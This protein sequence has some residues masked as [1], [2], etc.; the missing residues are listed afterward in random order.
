[1]DKSL[2]IKNNH[3][4]LML[5]E[6]IHVPGDMDIF[7]ID[8]NY[9]YIVYNKNYEDYLKRTFNIEI[10]EGDNILEIF[11][12][13]Q[14]VNKEKIIFD[15]ALGG[16]EFSQVGNYEENNQI[17]YY[18]DIYK[19]LKDENGEVAG[20]VV[21]YTNITGRKRYER[22]WEIL[23]NISEKVNTN[24]SLR[25]FIEY[26]RNQLS[27][28]INTS[29]FYVSLYNEKNDTYTFPYFV[30]EFDKVD[31]VKQYSLDKS[32]TDYVRKS[33]SPLLK[34]RAKSEE[35]RKSGKIEV[36]GTNSV[37]WLGVPLKIED[38]TIGVMVVQ[39]YVKEKLYTS[40]DVDL[41][42]FI[43]GHIAHAVKRKQAENELRITTNSL[44]YAQSIAKLGQCKFNIQNR[45]V[46]LS[47]EARVIFGFEYDENTVLISDIEEL[48]Y[49]K[50]KNSIQEILDNT[51][52]INEIFE[53]DIR[54]INK[55]TKQLVFVHTK[56]ELES[57]RKDKGDIINVMIQDVTKQ[58]RDK[59]ELKKAKEKAE[60]SDKLKS[61]FLAN[62]SH[63]IR[64]PMNAIVGFS[65]LMAKPKLALKSR[66]RYADF[67]NSSANN[68]MKLINDII[69][70]AKIEA[71]QISII[72]KP[73]NV[74]KML[75]ELYTS[76]LQLRKN[77]K[78]EYIG[79]SVKK[80]VK[81]EIFYIV[82]D[83]LR[84]SQ[85]LSNL[86]NNAIKFI[87]EGF[88]EFGYNFVDSKTL[89]F[90][91][92][93]TGPGIPKDKEELI[94]SRFGQIIDNE[95]VHPGGTGLGLSITK[96]LVEA[97]DG[98]IRFDSEPE[99]GSTFY[100]TIP[101]DSVNE[102]DIIEED[103]MATDLN[104]IQNLDI[105]IVEDNFAN[106]ELITDVIT[107]NTKKN[108][109]YY[110][111]T[112][113]EAMKITDERDFDIIFMDIKLPD[114][115]GFEVTEYIRKSEKEDK[116]TPIVGLS[117]HAMKDTNQKCKDVGM[118]S[119]IS[120]PFVFEKFFF[121]L[122]KFTVGKNRLQKKQIENPKSMLKSEFKH[123]DLSLL[124]PLY[125]DD[126][127]KLKN[128]VR[129]YIENIDTNIKKLSEI[130]DSGQ[131]KQISAYGHTLKSSLL[132]LGLNTGSE[133]AKGIELNASEKEIVRTN[134]KNLTE[135]WDSAKPEAVK[136][137]S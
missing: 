8:K 103:D 14:D 40:N 17:Y 128:I 100:F 88:I 11:K 38:K 49:K 112:G 101:F 61:A 18:K 136:Y 132:Y 46:D 10:K 111:A 27:K 137:T 94:F 125:K 47:E 36:F 7:A 3:F 34:D 73:A 110:A 12:D 52:I 65:K 26:I 24:E 83:P 98:K 74:N 87:E 121:T 23:L 31:Q 70:I 124:M 113:K 114:I 117:A 2:N 93:D 42:A 32:V 75:S 64:T 56:S 77:L 123:L 29:N 131:I 107:K 106:Q 67:I 133:N 20:I 4:K 60:E 105:L 62:M 54:L 85:I 30:D 51:V 116:R 120:K 71:G 9:R 5:K 115:D 78:K 22:V 92:K 37:S 16:V 135:I 48:L 127:L 81:A 86:L 108:T 90:F 55:K 102:G 82:T 33:G 45:T 72:K 19:P 58:H 104:E 119:F 41:M 21:Y 68:L 129:L 134:F 118:D 91:V 96:H 53:R 97:L 39:N 15:R 109:L 25:D 99:K 13:Y 76:F 63:E 80:S 35:L 28:L 1:M 66:E 44:K 79:I 57:K 84:L 50:D 69:D 126:E 130:I 95:I 59:L 122:A 43:S 6:I 89:E